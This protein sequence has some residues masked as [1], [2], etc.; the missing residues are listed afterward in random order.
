MKNKFILAFIL[1]FVVVFSIFAFSNVSAAEV[2]PEKWYEYTKPDIAKMS[3]YVNGEIVWYGFCEWNV[4]TVRWDCITE[5]Y[6]IPALERGE[7]AEIK[8]SF[9]AND[10]FE[11]ASVRAWI[12]GYHEDI[13]AESP[14][15]DIFENKTYTKTLDLYIPSDI[16]ARDTYTIHVDI[17]HKSDLSGIDEA[18]IET[19]IQRMANVLEIM[20][21]ELYDSGNY[22]SYCG[23]CTVTFNA[24]TIIYV[25]VAVKNRG[26]HE[27]EDVYVYVGIKD[28]C[29]ERTVYLGDLE[30]SDEEDNDNEDTK[31]VTIALPIPSD[32]KIGTYTLEVE[33]YN[34]EVSD[35][36]F[37]NLMIEGPGE[38]KK[39][40]EGQVEIMP[41]ITSNEIEVGKGAVYTILVA[42]FGDTTEDFVISVLGLEGGCEGACVGWAEATINPQAFSLSPGENKLVNVYLAASEN[43]VEGEHIFSVKVQHN[44]VSKQFTF[45]ANITN[46]ETGLDMSLKTILMIIGLV[47]AAVII[48]LLIVLLTQKRPEKA[49]VEESYY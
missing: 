28:L 45:T 14:L 18:D 46:G 12:G 36:E 7:E 10:D 1:V 29:I 8:V 47:L 27:A 17:E 20:S 16:D 6:E 39:E 43:A 19:E 34:N 33:A 21:V 26:S 4:L 13:E 38:D 48:V 23:D 37:R 24:G 11:E 25:D 15:F 49:E 40:K 30:E 5:Q 44:S 22:Y 2:K 41:Q 42:N 32:T 3:V 35:K 31:T 9:M